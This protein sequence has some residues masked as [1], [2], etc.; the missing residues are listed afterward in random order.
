VG[1]GNPKQLVDKASFSNTSNQHG[2]RK[3][4][5]R[6]WTNPL[7]ERDDTKQNDRRS[8]KVIE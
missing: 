4:A 5:L 8:L 1:R 6:R 2:L 7:L 3:S